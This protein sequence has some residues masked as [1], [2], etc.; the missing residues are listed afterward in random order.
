MTR[1]TITIGLASLIAL[2]G[3][4][5]SYAMAANRP[6]KSKA[7]AYRVTATPMSGS[8]FTQDTVNGTDGSVWVLG[9]V[10]ENVMAR[11]YAASGQ[12]LASAPLPLAQHLTAAPGGG[13][14]FVGRQ[15]REINSSFAVGYIAANGAVAIKTM[16]GPDGQPITQQTVSIWDATLGPDGAVYF[17]SNQ[18]EKSPGAD[19]PV[20]QTSANGDLRPSFIGRTDVAT[21]VTSLRRVPG[22]PFSLAFGPGGAVWF[23]SRTDTKKSPINLS[24]LNADGS[25]TTVA[26][27]PKQAVAPVAS[28]PGNALWA[29]R[30]GYVEYITSA[31]YRRIFRLPVGGCQTP[32]SSGVAADGSLWFQTRSGGSAKCFARLGPRAYLVRVTP[33]GVITETRMPFY[34]GAS[35]YFDTMAITGGRTFWMHGVSTP[36]GGDR[37][38]LTYRVELTRTSS[39]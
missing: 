16:V 6:A 4:T 19:D 10:G 25:V 38:T 32:L 14:Y 39:K 15:S 27:Y 36:R 31:G 2:S 26:T 30:I 8:G 11:R 28:A 24:R 35:A 34:T 20:G 7:P 5:G 37:A 23:T 12:L 22:L 33:K 17:V 18:W 29:M 3:V 9:S 21:G 1:T 13:T